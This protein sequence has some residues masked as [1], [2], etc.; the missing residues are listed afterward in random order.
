MIME[1]KKEYEIN[2]IT[3]KEA[4]FFE[5]KG[6]LCGM[7]YNDKIYDT[8]YVYRTFPNMSHNKFI[9]IKDESGEKETE[10]GII[11]DLEEFDEKTVNLLTKHLDNR[12]FVPEI[13]SIKSIKDKYGYITFS[14]TTTS[15][16]TEF[17]AR[18]LFR[19]V[20]K[21][22]LGYLIITDVDG[23]RYKV[24]TLL[25]KG[26]KNANYLLRFV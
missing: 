9:V 22:N 21:T 7:K 26:G 13:L 11:R 17:A 14:V 4:S 19:N 23:N 6:G 12:Y 10:I 25:K 20:R 5:N 15:G 24:D 1:E 8:V 18:D 2:Y 3:P 16:D